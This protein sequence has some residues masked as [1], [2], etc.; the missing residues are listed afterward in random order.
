MFEAFT[1]SVYAA[2]DAIKMKISDLNVMKK[3]AI[4]FRNLSI[5]LPLVMMC[6]YTGSSFSPSSIAS[7]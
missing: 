1:A 7:S 6:L 5:A 4:I 2:H 3:S